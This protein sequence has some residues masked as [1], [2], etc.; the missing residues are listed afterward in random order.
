MLM[1]NH[2]RG[3]G[4]G[5]GPIFQVKVSQLDT[6]NMFWLFQLSDMTHFALASCAADKIE[7]Q[8]VL[9]GPEQSGKFD[10]AIVQLLDWIVEAGTMADGRHTDMIRSQR[11]V[12]VRPEPQLIGNPTDYSS[13]VVP[14]AAS[15]PP[16][17]APVQSAPPAAASNPYLNGTAAPQ[18]A[19][20]MQPVGYSANPYMVQHGQPQ[21][22]VQHAAQPPQ[23]PLQP[24]QP[25]QS[26]G[27]Q[28]RHNQAP[29]QHGNQPVAAPIRQAFVNSGQ[30]V[31]ANCM[32]IADLSP[33]SRN[34]KITARVSKK[35]D[36]RT[37]TYKSGDRQGTQGNLLSFELLDSS[38]EE[39]R[40]TFFGDT[41]KKFD[42][43]L[44]QGSVYSFKGGRVK[45]ADRR[46]TKCKHE[47]TFD[48]NCE[49]LAVD[50]TAQPDIPQA[51]FA[52]TPLSQLA[53]MQPGTDVD[54]AGVLI[55][56][57]EVL[58]VNL[59]A[60]GTKKRRNMT[61]FDDSEA[62]CRFT[63]WGSD[64]EKVFQEGT[65]LLVKA[66]RLSDFGGRSLN[67]GFSTQLVQGDYAWAA[68]DRAKQLTQWYSSSGVDAK[69]NAKAL[70]SS[71]GGGPTV[72]IGELIELDK[73]L[74]VSGDADKTQNY[75]TVLPA[76]ITFV[77]PGK[78]PF[79]YA[80]PQEVQTQNFKGEQ[81]TRT[82]NKK[83]EQN[84]PQW[85]CGNGHSCQT[86]TARWT[87][88]FSVADHSG[89]IFVSA[90]DDVCQKLLDMPASRVAH[91]WEQRDADKAAALELEG[92]FQSAQFK[93]WR[94]R[95][96][97]KKEVWNDEERSKVSLVDCSPVLWETVAK[98]KASEVWT[99]L[100][101]MR[102]M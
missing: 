91:M 20:S 102:D 12:V 69:K 45:L 79:Y 41:A 63:I 2:R 60:G 18:P 49:I 42:Q 39:T 65:V 16:P 100:Q 55:E 27:E 23:Q 11:M 61:L 87:L 81:V 101:E 7:G 92:L 34:W 14:P 44:Q 59:R 77:N 21:S 31:E 9:S 98:A 36:M 80:C 56:V 43:I 96:R 15:Q 10:N 32:T 83:C 5:G 58:D 24:L 57:E 95:L 37:F 68:H 88:N 66:A 4:G 93:R 74:A 26:Y 86:P 48:D 40:G 17:V 90:F 30:P 28:M 99:A 22:A 84:G 62:T 6:A 33:Y 64:A 73:S 3:G 72:L 1:T 38:G 85:Q 35:G 53:T 71:G 70:S 29:F 97:S 50:N 54:V 94:M 75:H 52:F 76:T 67:G 19:Q 13:T 82:C 25:H 47:I 78:Q 89:S 8:H 51:V 46:W